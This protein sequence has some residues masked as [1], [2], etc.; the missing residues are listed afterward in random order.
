MNAVG[1]VPVRLD[2][3]RLHQKAITD[4]YG[5]PMFVHTI[6]RAELA[7]KLDAVF[8]ATD[9]DLISKI[10][11][12][13]D[14]KVI[15]TGESHNNSTE[16]VAEACKNIDCDIIVNIQGDEPLLSPVHVDKIV[17][18]MLYDSKVQVSIGITRFKK[19]N[20]FSD[21]KA[22]LD[23]NGDILYCSRNDI[24]CNYKGEINEY[25]RLVFIVPHRKEW[26][27]KYLVWKP[28][29]LEL[30]EDNHFLRLIE[31]GIKIKAVEIEDANI[32]V[33]TK[34]DLDEIKKLMESDTLKYKYIMKRI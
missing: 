22:V 10:A 2:S 14:I 34:E 31:N 6:K 23:L 11:K 21:I 24:P 28:T 25:W 15:M 1:I 3:T 20:S 18:P 13:Y 16:R 33:D 12:K 27:Q 29:P 26:I 30:L 9:S 17:E 4:I 5:L 8:L 32:S 7:E 19:Q